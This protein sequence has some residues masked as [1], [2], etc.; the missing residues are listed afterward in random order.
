[1]IPDIEAPVITVPQTTTDQWG[2]KVIE[3]SMSGLTNFPTATWSV[4]ATDNVAVTNG[5]V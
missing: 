2:N 5:P 3:L 4:S 1:M